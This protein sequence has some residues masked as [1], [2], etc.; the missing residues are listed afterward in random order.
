MGRYMESV[1][2][3]VGRTGGRS[4]G[5]SVMSLGQLIKQ[6]DYGSPAMN[7]TMNLFLFV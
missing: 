7:F 5:Q 4:A 3:S 2:R 1:A 6:V